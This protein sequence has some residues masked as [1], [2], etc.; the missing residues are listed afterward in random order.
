MAKRVCIEPGC[1]TVSDS[2]RCPACTRAKDKARGT[3]QQRGY[4]VHHDRLRAA[5][6]RKLNAGAI[7]YCW[8]PDCGKRINPHNWTL[9]HCDT[10]R[11]RYHGPECPPCDYAV[12]G[13]T[14]C[15]HESH[16]A[17]H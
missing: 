6:Q 17:T 1:P 5:W 12:T 7:V 14:G 2:T 16:Q 8:R 3:R 10:D 4:D 9:G 13:R 15:P 11:N